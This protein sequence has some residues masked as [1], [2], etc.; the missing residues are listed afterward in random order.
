M[1]ARL[2]HDLS[3]VR[4]HTDA[5]AAAS[6]RAVNAL[7]Y[8]VGQHVVFGAQQYAPGS[9][10]GVHLLG[11]ELAHVL[12][13]RHVR[14]T[15]LAS[16]QLGD[17]E[18]SLERD[19]AALADSLLEAGPAISAPPGSSSPAVLQR[20]C[21]AA[22][23]GVARV[24]GPESCARSGPELVVGSILLFCR[25]STEL[26]E[27]ELD[28]LRSLIVEAGTARRVEI[29]GNA[30][31]DGPSSEYNYNLACKRA[32]A[33]AKRFRAGGV[34]APIT[35]VTHGPTTAYGP[36]PAANRNAVVVIVAAAAKREAEVSPPKQEAGDC[37]AN[38]TAYCAARDRDPANLWLTCV[39]QVS[40]DVCL[41]AFRLNAGIS[42][43]GPI[44]ARRKASW[45]LRMNA[46]M[47]K[48]WNA[49]IKGFETGKPQPGATAAWSAAIEVCATSGKNTKACCDAQ[50]VGEQTGLTEC[51]P[52]VG[53]YETARWG[54]PAGWITPAGIRGMD[55]ND[56][57]GR[58]RFGKQFCCPE[59]AFT[60]SRNLQ[61]V[62]APAEFAGTV[63][64]IVQDL[65]DQVKI[66][67]ERF[68]IPK[69]DF[70]GP[71]WQRHNPANPRTLGANEVYDAAWRS[72]CKVR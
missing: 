68:G 31:V 47:F 51:L 67:G 22:P 64:R 17:P 27:S 6:V 53:R 12:Q 24:R 66:E 69:R 1:E 29:H 40:G 21:P 23:S 11:H 58:I 54:D 52:V 19:A 10:E 55:F 71:F 59:A 4:V 5:T 70:C 62:A 14:G 3:G 46:C 26:K 72:I 20:A 8:T 39:C 32:D 2:A 13:Q 36:E 45:M 30:S 42:D 28:Y 65:G 34:T 48:K 50:V 61:G 49:A 25:D 41:N 60:T 56:H 43:L 15:G 38:H 18:T 57:E 9:H 44:Q 35:L 7:A 16:L 37:D 33:L 63:P